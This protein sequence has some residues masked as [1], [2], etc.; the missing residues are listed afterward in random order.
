VHVYCTLFDR[1]YLTRG[2][3][4]YGSLLRHCREFRLVVLC[5]DETV[6]DILAALA[7]QNM[8]VVRLSS[9][10]ESDPELMRT[11]SQRSPVEFYFTC[12][13]ALMRFIAHAHPEA[14][15]ITYHDSDLYYFS[16]PKFLEQEHADDAIVL[17]PHRFPPRLADRNRFGRFNAGWVSAGCGAEGLRFIDWWRA[18]CIEWCRL[19][20]QGDRFADQK[21]LDRVPD[22]FSHVSILDHPGVN[23]APWNIEEADIRQSSDSV[24][25]DGKP[26]VLFHFHGLRR[27]LYRIY[28][29]GLY[30]YGVNLSPLVRRS[31]YR[32]YL[33]YLALAEHRVSRLSAGARSSSI[34]DRDLSGQRESLSRIRLALRLVASGTAIV[35]P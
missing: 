2:L 17:T 10:A 21:Y 8:E 13:P 26:L 23:L 6:P 5:L 27:V 16:D 24:V 31:I 12:K 7:L 29:S 25:V 9:L 3:A 33:S 30:G 18:R 34:V 32:P 1:N 15:R 14:R 4:L 28:D 35:G 22:L 20:L 11:R 19:E